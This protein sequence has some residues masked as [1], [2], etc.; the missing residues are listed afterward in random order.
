MRDSEHGIKHY[1]IRIYEIEDESMTVSKPAL[2]ASAAISLNG[3]MMLGLG[4][5]SS[6]LIAVCMASF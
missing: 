4:I 6:A 1:D 5:F 2:L 3:I